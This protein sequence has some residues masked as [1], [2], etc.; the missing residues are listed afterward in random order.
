[1][2]KTALT[3]QRLTM[4]NHQKQLWQSMIDQI[5]NYLDGKNKDFYGLVGSLEGALDSCSIID[6]QVINKWYDFW[7]PL[8][9]RRSIQGNNVDS[10][11]AISELKKM[12]HFLLQYKTVSKK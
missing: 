8:E 4:T 10:Q 9:I 1:M 2:D 3:L 11:K 12:K 7:T 6:S 5:E